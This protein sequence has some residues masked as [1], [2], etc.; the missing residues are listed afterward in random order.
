MKRRCS[1]Y[2]SYQ[3]FKLE[4]CEMN[5]EIT[6]PSFSQYCGNCLMNAIVVGFTTLLDFRCKLNIAYLLAELCTTEL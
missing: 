5:K 2:I 6:W 1:H 3:L 4:A